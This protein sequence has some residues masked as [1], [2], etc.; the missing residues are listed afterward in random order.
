MP[1]RLALWA[2]VGAKVDRA[3]ARQRIQRKEA[4]DDRVGRRRLAEAEGDKVAQPSRPAALGRL[5]SAL[6]DVA[7]VVQ[8]RGWT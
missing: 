1:A 7:C 2:A 8:A 6:R 3:H 4:R 5:R